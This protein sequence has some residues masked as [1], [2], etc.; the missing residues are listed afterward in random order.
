MDVNQSRH[1]CY[2]WTSHAKQCIQVKLGIWVY[3]QQHHPAAAE[4]IQNTEH[5]SEK[6]KR[7]TKMTQR[8]RHG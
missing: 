6:K 5:K 4:Q 8:K 3:W 7:A 1:L 2:E